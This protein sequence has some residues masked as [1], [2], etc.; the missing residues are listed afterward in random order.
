M[1]VSTPHVSTHASAQGTRAPGQGKLPLTTRFTLGKE[2]TDEQR[3]FLEEHG[4]LV[5][6]EVASP[7]EVRIILNTIKR[8]K[9]R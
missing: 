7:T 3:A 8:L 4:F 1:N 5:F 2:I 9:K 6:A